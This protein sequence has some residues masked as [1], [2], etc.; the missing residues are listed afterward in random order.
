MLRDVRYAAAILFVLLAVGFVALW[1]RSYQWS[2]NVTWHAF[3]NYLSVSSARGV[4]QCVT[5]PEEA[6][7]PN[8]LNWSSLPMNRWLARDRQRV[9]FKFIL[10]ELPYFQAMRLPHW[11]LAASSLALGALLAFKLPRRFS[12]RTILVATTLLAALLG[13]AVWAV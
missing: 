13:L 2:D 12:L 8:E 6:P 10:H 7:Q 5:Y 11:F 3:G 4:L 9:P 1:A